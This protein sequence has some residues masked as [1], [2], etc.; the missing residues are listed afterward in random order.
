MSIAS[1]WDKAAGKEMWKAG[2]SDKEIAEHFGVS[3]S[4][5]CQIRKKYWEAEFGAPD[6]EPAEP[7][8]ETTSSPE[9]PGIGIVPAPKDLEEDDAKV[10]IRAMELM[11]QNL[12]GM[13][14]VMTAQILTNLWAW[15]S[16]SDLLAAREFLDYLIERAAK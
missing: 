10:M 12:H 1:K 15:D 14:A 5:V 16:V 9:G 4:A 8:L 3:A 13:N 7:P 11:T 6:Q 2:K